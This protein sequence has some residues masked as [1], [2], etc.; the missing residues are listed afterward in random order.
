MRS[1]QLK[2][3]WSSSLSFPKKSA[4][5]RAELDDWQKSTKAPVPKVP[6]PECV[7]KSEKD[8]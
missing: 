5:L 4:K 8:L 6:N 7:L 1:I 2:V 3:K